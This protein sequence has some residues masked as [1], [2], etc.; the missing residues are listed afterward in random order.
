MIKT[1]FLNIYEE[2][3]KLYEDLKVL[4]DDEFFTLLDST[5][6]ENSRY[7]RDQ[8]EK[9][10]GYNDGFYCL[11]DDD[12]NLLAASCMK[13]SI[14]GLDDLYINEIQ[15]FQKGAGAKLLKEIFTKYQNVWL[16][17]EPGSAR[18]KNYYS[19]FWL[20]EYM[21]SKDK[22]PYN[23][24]TYFFTNMEDIE[25]FKTAISKEYSK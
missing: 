15:S 3:N 9:L 19:Q 21:L 10:K 4:N 17:A 22:S 14:L 11:V 20:S 12:N 13:K 8:F 5:K 7:N 18:L 2:L 23:V 16:M 25:K 1:E 24:D 6:I